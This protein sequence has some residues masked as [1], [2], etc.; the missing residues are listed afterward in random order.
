[1][2]VGVLVE[3]VGANELDGSTLASDND[4]LL[5]LTLTSNGA[6]LPISAGLAFAS[7]PKFQPIAFCSGLLEKKIM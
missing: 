3:L 1:M 7:M 4:R 2:T 6:S 5:L